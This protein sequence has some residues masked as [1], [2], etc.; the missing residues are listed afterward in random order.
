M[1][2]NYWLDPDGNLYPCGRGIAVHNQFA[3]NYLIDNSIMTEDELLDSYYDPYELLHQR[4]WV[5]IVIDTSLTQIVNIMGDCIS[6][7]NPM[8]NTMCPRMNDLQMTICKSLCD[9]YNFDFYKA[10]NDPRFW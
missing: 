6:L 3:R 5:R 2:I 4:G 7:S 10:I 8:Y 1:R 9:L